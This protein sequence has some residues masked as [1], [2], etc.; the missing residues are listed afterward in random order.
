VYR[1]QLHPVRSRPTYL[2]TFEHQAAPAPA[3]ERLGSKSKNF[4][5]S[6]I[7][8]IPILRLAWTGGRTRIFLLFCTFSVLP[9]KL[10]QSR[11]LGDLKIMSMPQFSSI[12][13]TPTLPC[14]SRSTG[15][16]GRQLACSLQLLKITVRPANDRLCGRVYMFQGQM[17]GQCR[18]K[19][20]SCVGV[21]VRCRIDCFGSLKYHVV[22]TARL[23]P[24]CQVSGQPLYDTLCRRPH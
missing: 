13:R 3:N 11:S 22:R 17:R 15:R 18:F 2:Q 4:R 7:T 14:F 10:R 12:S 20:V 24:R 5:A 19:Q 21:A 8:W 16:T 1:S 6:A 9:A 23:L